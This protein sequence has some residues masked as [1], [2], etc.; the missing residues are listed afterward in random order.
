[1]SSSGV[2]FAWWP[3]NAKTD[4]GA[5]R[6]CWLEDVWCSQT[7]ELDGSVSKTRYYTDV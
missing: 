5:Y 3:V 7:H 2:W 4:A 6:W 1:M